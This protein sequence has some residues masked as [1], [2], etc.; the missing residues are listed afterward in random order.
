ML[1]F[2]GG[3]A[4]K[5]AE[6][7]TA[8]QILHYRQRL[9]QDPGGSFFL[10]GPRGTGKSTLLRT[11]FPDALFLDLLEPNLLRRFM[12]RPERLHEVLAGQEKAPSVVVIDEVQK[13]PALLDVVHQ[14]LESPEHPRF[15]LTGSSARKL[16]QAGVDLLAGRAL[17]R[18]LHP[19]LAGELGET[20]ELEKALNLGMVPLVLAAERPA[21]ALATYVGLYLKEEVQ[22]EGLVR[23]LDD[24]ARFL[25]AISF[26][27]AAQLNLS[28]V[29][30]ECEVS[31]KT[32]EGY[33]SILEDLMLGFRL[34]V[35]SRRAKRHL[36]HH[37]KFFFFDTGVFRR[38]RPAGPLDRREEID[39]AALEG[40]VAQHLRAWLDY[41]GG[42]ADLV[43]TPE[44]LCCWR[45]KSGSEVDFVL[46]GEQLFA[47]IEVKNS[48]AVR[49]QDLRGLKA[50]R[51]DYPEARCTLL[52]RGEERLLIDGIAC[53]PVE[54]FLRALH[55]ARPL[56]A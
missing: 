15:V 50:F 46:Y 48:A 1:R 22:Q 5:E 12:A 6:M 52:Y 30:R 8:G 9:F 39:G 14:L 51:E 32:A 29:A 31:R 28:E 27:H 24:F 55:P 19:F 33:L 56:P 26:S 47:A 18:S 36:A 35:F 42:P 40:M 17:L 7:A 53:L 37:P 21:D 16:K 54:P 23:R 34:P 4:K 45:T 49:P 3:S 41:A 44:K 11:L 25:E 2:G 38:L 43:G 10:F 13:A 20:F